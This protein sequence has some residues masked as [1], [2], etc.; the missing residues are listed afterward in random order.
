[1]N[2]HIIIRL[3]LLAAVAGPAHA[4][5]YKCMDQGGNATLTDVPCASL[6]PG[7]PEDYAAAAVAVPEAEQEQAPVAAPV[8]AASV[9]V[10]TRISLAAGEM[11]ALARQRQAVARRTAGQPFALDAATLKAARYTLT[12]RDS[13]ATQ[14]KLAALR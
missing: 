4:E 1:M 5:V 11:P 2:R 12:A 8:R 3:L 13:A 14:Q 9:P 6:A 7:A 10:I